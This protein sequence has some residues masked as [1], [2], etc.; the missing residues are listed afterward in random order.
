MPG[1]SAHAV[2]VLSSAFAH[3][4]NNVLM[5]VSGN[6]QLLQMVAAPSGS[7]VYLDRIGHGVDAG[8]E[9]AAKISR[10]ASLT[11]QPLEP[12]GLQQLLRSLPRGTSLDGPVLPEVVVCGSLEQLQAMMQAFMS[13]LAGSAQTPLG[14]RCVEVESSVSTGC[15]GLVFG[16]LRD[17]Q[18]YH[19]VST[20][21]PTG[22][23]LSVEMAF[24]VVAAVRHG[25]RVAA[26]LHE[27][28]LDSLMLVLP[29][30]EREP[31]RI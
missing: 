28:Q 31:V 1:D 26:S 2:N 11:D 19:A 10:L 12:L 7:Q 18:A 3:E 4:L 16:D 27:S 8:C 6:V 29:V 21:L 22:A 17:M 14:V 20:H 23:S 13:A 5:A 30:S 25:G 24:A 15:I 9:L